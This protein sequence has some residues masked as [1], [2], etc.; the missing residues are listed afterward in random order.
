[1]EKAYPSRI[2]WLHTHMDKNS[3][4]LRSD[5]SQTQT[6]LPAQDSSARK[7]SPH[8][9]WLQKPMGIELVEEAAGAQSSS[10]LGNPH[11]THLLRIAPL[12]ATALVWQLEGHQWYTGRDRSVWHQGE[13]R[14]LS[15]C[16][17]LSPQS[18]QVGAISETPSMSVTLCLPSWISTEALP[19][20]TYRAHPSCFSIRMAG[21]GS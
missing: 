19:H 21:L 3:G 2:S 16:W 5:E 14:P 10:F 17:V 1:M 12:W 4:Y 18:R 11:T 15:L 9:F 20:S 6:M 13:H 8:N 7:I